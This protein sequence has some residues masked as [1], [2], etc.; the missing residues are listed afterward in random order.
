MK[1]CRGLPTKVLMSAGAYPEATVSKRWDEAKMH[2]LTSTLCKMDEE[3]SV[4]SADII[5]SKT[6]EDQTT[7]QRHD[8]GQCVVDT[9]ISPEGP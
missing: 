6:S 2:E 5:T 8:T 3:S 4:P 1:Q 9:P 7:A